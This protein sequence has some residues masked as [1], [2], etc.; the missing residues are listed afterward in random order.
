MNITIL[1]LFPDMFAGFTTN[2]I[3]KRALGKGVATIN[4]VNIRDYTKDKYGRT[5]TPPIGE[6]PASSKKPSPSWTPWL[7]AERKTPTSS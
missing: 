6:G 7:L 3:M 1:T 4:V 5:D 2:S